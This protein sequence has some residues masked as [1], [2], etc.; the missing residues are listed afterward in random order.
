MSVFSLPD[1][2]LIPDWKNEIF[3]W[4]LLLHVREI[5]KLLK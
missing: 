5:N 2:Y 1:F 3:Y 4:N